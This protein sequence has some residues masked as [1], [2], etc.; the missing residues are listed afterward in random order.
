MPGKAGAEAHKRVVMVSVGV[1]MTE[2]HERKLRLHIGK[3][4]TDTGVGM[5]E[6]QGN[7]ETE[8]EDKGQED[9][10]DGGLRIRETGAKDK[11]A[12]E[13][14]QNKLDGKMAETD[15]GQEQKS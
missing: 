6:A 8:K 2:W 12:K 9:K 5:E 14:S 11:E 7:Q 1:D 3:Y 13:T 4:V 10:T 15:G